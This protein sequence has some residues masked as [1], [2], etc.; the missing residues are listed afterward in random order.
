MSGESDFEDSREELDD[1]SDMESF[2]TPKALV[3]GGNL[4]YSWKTFKQEFEIYILAAEKTKKSKEVQAA[5]FLNLIGEYGRQLFNNFNMAAEDK[6]DM[7]KIIEEF[8]Q[9]CAPKKNEIYERFK[10][11]QRRQ[12][13]GESFDSF[14]TAIQKLIRTC[15]FQEED[16][17]L[18]DRIVIGISDTKLQEK[19][20]SREEDLTKDKVIK[21]CRAAEVARKQAKDL[22]EQTTKRGCI[23]SVSSSRNKFQ[24][25]NTKNDKVNKKII[26]IKIFHRKQNVLDAIGTMM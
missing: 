15:N 9:F 12:M 10:F 2:N 23:D 13:D 8:D 16:N 14:L 25:N 21:Q 26:K 7:M 24:K 1:T 17:M 19:L 4:D 3:E 11:N 20:L 5:I 22:C 6:K 18:R